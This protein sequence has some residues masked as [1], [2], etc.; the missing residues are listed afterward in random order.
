MTKPFSPAAQA[1]WNAAY[2]TPED[3][4]YE[5]DLAAALKAAADQC[6][7][8]EIRE[9]DYTTRRWI[10]LDDLLAIAAELEKDND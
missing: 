5:H 6:Y 1:V 8:Q 4:P 9:A 10:C 7:S 3:C 2:N